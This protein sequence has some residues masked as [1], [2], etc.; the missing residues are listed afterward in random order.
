MSEAAMDMEVTI[1]DSKEKREVVEE[2][3]GRRDKGADGNANEE[4][5]DGG[6]TMRCTKKRKAGGRGGGIVSKLETTV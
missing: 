5:G 3:E 6:T 1:R 4:N 2:A